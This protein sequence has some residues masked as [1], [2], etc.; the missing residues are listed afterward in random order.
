ME[1]NNSALIIGAS[2]QNPFF[3]L[4]SAIRSRSMLFE[5]KHI[6]N[7]ALKELFDRAALNASDM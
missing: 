5:P 1:K 3:S 6:T 2:T 7:E 4:T